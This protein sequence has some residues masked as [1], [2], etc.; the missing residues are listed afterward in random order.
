MYTLCFLSANIILFALGLPVAG[1][2]PFRRFYQYGTVKH[3]MAELGRQDPTKIQQQC[4]GASRSCQ[5]SSVFERLTV[6][7]I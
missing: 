3:Y 4:F 5:P 7:S 2:A 1:D 6:A